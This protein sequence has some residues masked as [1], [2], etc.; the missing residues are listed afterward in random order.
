M[1]Q[2]VGQIGV[3]T[4][5]EIAS[6]PSVGDFVALLKPRVMSLV[7][8]TGFTGLVLAPGSLHPALAIIA[9]FCIALGAGA[10]G[11]LNMWYERDIDALMSR[12]A[13]R[14]IPAGRMAP[15][16]AVAF[17]TPLAVSS[18]TILG[19]AT[20]WVAAGLLAFSILF[21]VLVYTVWLKRRTPQN[22]VIG[23]AAGAL[24]PVIGWAAVTGGVDLLPLALFLLVFL[25]TP[26]HF[27][28]LALVRRGDYARAGVPMLPVVAGLEATRW[29]ILAYSGL[30]LPVSLIPVALGA[31]GWIYGVA[32]AALGALFI[33]GALRVVTTRTDAAAQRLFGFSILYLALLFVALLID[34]GAAGHL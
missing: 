34:A 23:G 14:P 15:G 28:A 2:A 22:I 32:A 18:V 16:T 3:A 17:A 19:L 1:N 31:I 9:V 26:P 10:A 4:S 12:T 33:A 30:L 29:H 27:W 20:N 24:P 6:E 8:F 7:V 25:W 13:N 21:Y 5:V 11:A